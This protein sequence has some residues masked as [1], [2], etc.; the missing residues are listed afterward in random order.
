MP[1]H[2]NASYTSTIN[3][4]L[5]HWGDVNVALPPAKPLILALANPNPEITPEDVNAVRQDAI[6]ATAESL[7]RLGLVQS[8]DH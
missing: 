4:F 1:I 2:D 7:I 8:P 6:V 5:P 3:E